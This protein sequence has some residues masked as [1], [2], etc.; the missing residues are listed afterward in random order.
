MLGEVL[1]R[2]ADVIVRP[3]IGTGRENRRTA[4]EMRAARGG[5]SGFPAG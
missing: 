1:I 3:N 4:D 2:L 5:R